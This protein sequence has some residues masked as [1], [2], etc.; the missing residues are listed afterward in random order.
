M[1][2]IPIYGEPAIKYAGNPKP[3]LGV[4]VHGGFTQPYPYPYP[5]YPTRKPAWVLKPVTITI[6]FRIRLITSRTRSKRSSGWWVTR[7]IRSNKRASLLISGLRYVVVFFKPINPIFL[8]R[9]WLAYSKG[10][11]FQFSVI[12]GANLG[13]PPNFGGQNF[14]FIVWRNWL[15]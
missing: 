12:L 15:M 5:T 9:I 3:V 10:S 8:Y 6:L 4:R 11:N 2:A 13:R 7:W 1:I 14:I